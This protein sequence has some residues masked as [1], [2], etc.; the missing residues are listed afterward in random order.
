MTK[1]LDDLA[2]GIDPD[3]PWEHKDAAHL[4]SVSFRAWLE[5]RCAD[6]EAVDN[7]ALCRRQSAAKTTQVG[8]VVSKA[9]GPAVTRN[10]V[11][12]RLR[13]LTR[14]RARAARWLRGSWM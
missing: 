9:V 4:D 3:R 2:A 14:A 10:L 12:R 6:P 5:Q 8:F 1:A 13:H 7:V 11:K